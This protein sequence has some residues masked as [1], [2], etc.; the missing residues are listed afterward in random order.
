MAPALPPT[1]DIPLRVHAAVYRPWRMQL[2][3]WVRTAHA[4]HP[5]RFTRRRMVRA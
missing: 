3:A 4:D 2:P 5:A 1:A